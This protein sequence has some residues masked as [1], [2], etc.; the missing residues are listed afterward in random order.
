MRVRTRLRQ[1]AFHSRALLLKREAVP[2]EPTAPRL[3]VSYQWHRDA[4]LVLA[5]ALALLITHCGEQ[6]VADICLGDAHL[7]SPLPLQGL[8]HRLQHQRALK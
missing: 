6:L 3:D 8:G 5:D 2:P 4:L 1:F 7:E